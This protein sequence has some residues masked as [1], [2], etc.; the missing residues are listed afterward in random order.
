MRSESV[1]SLGRHPRRVLYVVLVAVLPAALALVP[2][3][4]RAATARND[5][6]DQRTPSQ[7]SIERLQYEALREYPQPT[8]W[9][10]RARKRLLAEDG[11]P[12]AERTYESCRAG[13]KEHLQAQWKALSAERVK[14]TEADVDRLQRIWRQFAWKAKGFQEDVRRCGL[15]LG[16]VL[17]PLPEDALA[18]QRAQLGR[19]ETV[20]RR[21]PTAVQRQFLATLIRPHTSEALDKL[22]RWVDATRDAEVRRKLW[23]YLV[24]DPDP[25][26]VE[27][28]RERCLS[29]AVVDEWLYVRLF[30]AK[31]FG[32]DQDLK[33]LIRVAP[34][35]RSLQNAL[36]ALPVSR[37]RGFVD[38]AVGLARDRTWPLDRRVAFV[39]AF[40]GVVDDT[41]FSKRILEFPPGPDSGQLKAAMLRGARTKAGYLVQNIAVRNCALSRQEPRGVRG[42]AVRYL[43]YA[44]QAWQ[45]RY[46]MIG[47]E[48][49][50]E[51]GR[52]NLAVLR[53]IAR[54]PDEKPELREAAAKGLITPLTEADHH[55]F[56]LKRITN[57]PTRLAA[58]RAAKRVQTEEATPADRT[59]VHFESR[60]TL[61]SFDKQILEQ[62]LKLLLAKLKGPAAKNDG[63]LPSDLE[64]VEPTPRFQGHSFLYFPVKTTKEL[65]PSIVLLAAPKAVVFG[66]D[67]FVISPD[68]RRYIQMEKSQYDRLVKEKGAAAPKLDPFFEKGPYK[69]VDPL[70][71]ELFVMMG[72][73]RVQRVV[74]ANLTG[75][76]A[77]NNEARKAI[78]APAVSAEMFERLLDAP[79]QPKLP[80]VKGA[81]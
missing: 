22:A 13:A 4:I 64:P 28:L 81:E 7:V 12:P 63:T 26:A 43:C 80:S 76:V 62:S 15:K 6:P 56:L 48:A 27:L 72:D 69:K 66:T 71:P 77:R 46:A 40:G 55:D 68:A 8:P 1:S 16:E 18:E 44:V 5:R 45:E 57:H 47:P 19:L 38:F 3:A 42:A 23:S 52:S 79:Y 34:S 41:D 21:D 75:V 17:T 37:Y 31:G 49:D 36:Y 67:V 74:R 2:L 60:M 53:Q 50:S 54:S 20:D 10:D 65:S 11:V 35:E 32:S 9:H 51:A 39:R 73:G 14:T 61:Y 70:E 33:R 29:G 24:I 78:G 25:R 30:E 58:I 59:F